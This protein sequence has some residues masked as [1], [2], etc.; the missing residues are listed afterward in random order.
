MIPVPGASGGMK[1]IYRYA[2]ELTQ[3]GHSV[4]I[5]FP[6]CAYKL[7]SSGNAVWESL[8]QIKNTLLNILRYRFVHFEQHFLEGNYQVPVWRINGKHIRDADAVIATAWPTAFDVEKLPSVSGDKFYFIQGF[9][10]WDNEELGIASYGLPLK[11]IS[12]ANW[13]RDS[14]KDVNHGAKVSVIHNGIDYSRFRVRR[15][16][17]D[18]N[19]SIL[20]M[21]SS[22]RIKGSEYGFKAI[23]KISECH[24]D[25][26]FTV[27]GLKRPKYIPNHVRFVENPSSDEIEKLYKSS[28]IYL[29]PSL[30]E[31]WGLTVIEAMAAGCAVVGTP[32]GCLTEIGH[33]GSN[34]LLSPIKDVDSMV[35]NVEKLSND[36]RLMYSLG[37]AASEVVKE[38]AWEKSV[39]Q[40]ED[41]LRESEK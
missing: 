3:R 2:K 6:L 31:G 16:P 11:Q 21:Y 15:V 30:E 27:F 28:D 35:A 22:L 19:L 7:E 39:I 37:Q 34:V 26:R 24:P 4:K 18:G 9:E 10:I 13:I 33:D 12:V 17:N 1:V 5:Y 41:L 14:V 36:R 40:F 32:T 8:V 25:F 23:C 38:F 20:M 29:F